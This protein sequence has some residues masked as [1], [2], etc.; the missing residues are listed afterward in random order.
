MNQYIVN[1][2]KYP[3]MQTVIK[4]IE[5]VGNNGIHD[6]KENILD[7]GKKM[8]NIVRNIRFDRK[9]I[10]SRL[11]N[12]YKKDL[13]LNDMLNIIEET[14]ITNNNKIEIIKY[15]ISEYEKEKV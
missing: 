7:I 8:G 3:N 2:S 14:L 6:I 9:K 15:R 10:I 11:Y 12:N 13:N 4:E 5:N 1:S